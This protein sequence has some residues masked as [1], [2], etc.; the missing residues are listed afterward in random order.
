[1]ARINP[2]VFTWVGIA[3]IILFVA[4][5]AVELFQ[6]SGPPVTIKWIRATFGNAGL[7][8]L[9][10]LIV[11]A[12]L[13][14]LPYRRSTMSTWKSKGAFIA[15]V[16]ALMT[17]MFG[18]P[19]LIFLISPVVEVPS[20]RGWTREIFGHAGPLIGTWVSMIGLLLIALGWQ[21]IHKATGLVTNGIYRFVR[22]PQYTGMFLFTLGWILHW[23]SVITLILWPVLV[24]AYV[25]LARREEAV[26]I[27]EFGEPYLEYAKKTPRFL[28]RVLPVKSG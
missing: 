19:L 4:I 2:K 16:I 7:I 17:E 26:V 22:H 6:H 13:A 15:F 8:V 9:N 27:E 14:L 5:Y 24:V 23:P 10:I 12:F 11:I 25:W 21:K 20:L 18:W 1:M 3:A 28:P